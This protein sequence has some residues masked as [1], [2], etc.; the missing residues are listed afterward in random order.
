MCKCLLMK[1]NTNSNVELD[2]A[3]DRPRETSSQMIDYAR[4]L[5]P[6]HIQS[7][8]LKLLLC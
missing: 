8:N 2:P 6:L 3:T 1:K 5:A 7:L 4:K